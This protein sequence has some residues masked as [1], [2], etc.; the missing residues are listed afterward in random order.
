T[1]AAGCSIGR[2]GGP[3]AAAEA[4]NRGALVESRP[5]TMMGPLYEPY[6]MT[7]ANNPY[8]QDRRDKLDKLRALGVDPYGQ[9][10]A[11]LQ[12]LAQVKA[13]YRDEMCA[14]Q[15]PVVKVAGRV[16]LIRRMGK[17]TFA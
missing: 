6:D 14:D 17:L 16:M 7:E 15:G 1:Q 5:A 11:D 8:E 12:P 13:A 3:G 4:A 10:T 9:R 2:I